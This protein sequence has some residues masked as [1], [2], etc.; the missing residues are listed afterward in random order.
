MP[1]YTFSCPNQHKFDQ[2][3][4]MKSIPSS[5]DCEECGL[6]AVRL[7]T[8]P[9]ISIPRSFD[10]RYDDDRAQHQAYLDSPE[11]KKKREELEATGHVVKTG[12]D[13][14]CI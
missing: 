6:Q 11:W 4:S 8:F 13:V 14:D 2:V 9:N 12:K 5:V 1:T 7:F 3:H 10:S